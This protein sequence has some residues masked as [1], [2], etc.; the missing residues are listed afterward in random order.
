[1]RMMLVSTHSPWCLVWHHKVCWVSGYTLPVCLHWSALRSP[2]LP[3]P[4]RCRG[5]RLALRRCRHAART[6]TPTRPGGKTASSSPDSSHPC[7]RAMSKTGQMRTQFNSY[8]NHWTFTC[9]DQQTVFICY[10]SI[11]SCLLTSKQWC[12][13]GPHVETTPEKS[14]VGGLTYQILLLNN[15]RVDKSIKTNG[16]LEIMIH[17][18]CLDGLWLNNSDL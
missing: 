15:N 8:T 17:N 12:N 1:M 3:S 6:H 18:P 11:C 5:I 14:K 7:A 9:S 10:C 4:R 13:K 16:H 2:P